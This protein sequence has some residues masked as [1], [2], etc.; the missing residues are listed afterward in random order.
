M[1]SPPLANSEDFAM[2]EATGFHLF[3]LQDDQEKIK[4]CKRQFALHSLE[5]LLKTQDPTFRVWL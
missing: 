3:S 4:L 2:G 1:V 5:L